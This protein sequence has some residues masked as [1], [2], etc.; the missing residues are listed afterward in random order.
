MKDLPEEMAK[1]FYEIHER[2]IF[3]RVTYAKTS[4]Q[5]KLWKDLAER[6]RIEYVES[7][8]Q[9]L[10]DQELMTIVARRSEL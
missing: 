5:S 7:F 8:R 6:D 4:L 2:M 1:R 10:A 9:L 3:L